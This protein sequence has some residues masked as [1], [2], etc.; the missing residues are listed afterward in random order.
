MFALHK[1]FAGS[2]DTAEK[3]H[4]AGKMQAVY[5]A[6]VPDIVLGNFFMPSPYRTYV[7]NAPAEHQSYN[8]YFN[9]WLDK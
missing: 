8:V 5:C 4:V 7:K 2:V 1:Q 3:L 9:L 6:K